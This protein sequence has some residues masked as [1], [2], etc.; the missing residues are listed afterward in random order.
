MSALAHY[1]EQ[2]GLATTTIALVRPH[3]ERIRPP[4]ALWVPFEL[5]RP[6]G[7]PNDPAFQRRVL[8]AALDLL[9]RPAGPV[10]E[11]YPEEAPEEARREEDEGGW[12]C[13]ISFAPPPGDPAAMT[14]AERFLDEVRQLEPWYGLGLERRG[15]TTVGASGLTV[16]EAARYIGAFLGAE[17][18]ASPRA[19]IGAGLAL[20]LACED[21]RA[22]YFESAL[23]QPGQGRATSDSIS[24]WFWT[25]TVAG[26]VFWALKE[27]CL[28][29]GD[30][31]MVAMGRYILVPR[32]QMKGVGDNP[33][34]SGGSFGVAPR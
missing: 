23:A 5:G 32:K 22:Y 29:S 24:D 1:F 18:P 13:A 15:R 7:V 2:E 10:L 19:D 30:P 25:E 33:E 9:R 34:F 17:P 8:R 26:E 21:L 16:P 12:A 11:D 31:M 28:K 3:A 20:K 6:L 14:L 27:V 4:R